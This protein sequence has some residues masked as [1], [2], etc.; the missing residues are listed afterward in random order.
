MN[1]SGQ[2]IDNYLCTFA[3]PTTVKLKH[4]FRI[5]KIEPFKSYELYVWVIGTA[6]LIRT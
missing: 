6:R 3:I 1:T 2:L 4:Y 5:D